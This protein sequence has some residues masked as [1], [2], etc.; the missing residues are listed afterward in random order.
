MP[1]PQPR[2][3]DT[4]LATTFTPTR[5]STIYPTISPSN[6]ANRFPQPGPNVCIIGAS[7]GIGAEMAVAYA[8]AGAVRLVLA[9]V[10]S[11]VR[12]GR[13]GEEKE[14][15][16]KRRVEGFSVDISQAGSVERL[17]ESAREFSPRLDILVLVSGLSGPVVLKVGDGEVADFGWVVDINVKGTYHI[18]HYF[19]PWLLESQGLKTF[20]AVGSFAGCIINGHI[21]NTAYCL[22]KFAQARLLEFISEQYAEEGLLA[23]SVHPGAVATDN[24]LKT[25]PDS[26]KEYLVDDP[27]LCGAFCVWLCLE[28]R[29]W[30]NGR[31]VS[32]KWDVDELLARKADIE[33][34]DLLKFGFR[35][36]DSPAG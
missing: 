3:A 13:L 6:P 23:V 15:G 20:I 36:G 10:E 9:G 26:F 24:A 17:V 1:Q 32:A 27:A 5:H 22:S 18:A 29:M 30:L 21:A 7:R 25:C 35:V 2:T 14:N 11:S 16:V 34:R 19:I 4:T 31:L 8:K 12:D 28:K 33:E